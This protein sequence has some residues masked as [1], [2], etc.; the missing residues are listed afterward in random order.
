MV[1]ALNHS[2]KTLIVFVVRSFTACHVP[3]L[4]P[5]KMAGCLESPARRPVLV[6]LER[7]K[8]SRPSHGSVQS[9]HTGREVD[10]IQCARAD[11]RRPG[12]DEA[13]IDAVLSE[14]DVAS[15]VTGRR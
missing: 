1:G 11:I 13:A 7:Q 14:V 12:L 5:L 10:R 2:S 4:T 6:L 3:S 15:T 8:H 9:C